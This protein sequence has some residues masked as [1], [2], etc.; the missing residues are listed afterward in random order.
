MKNKLERFMSS[1]CVK[2][3]IEP[4]RFLAFQITRLKIWAPWLTLL[5]F[6][7]SNPLNLLLMILKCFRKFSFVFLRSHKRSL[8]HFVLRPSDQRTV[9]QNWTACFWLIN[10]SYFYLKSCFKVKTLLNSLEKWW[11]KVTDANLF[12]TGCFFCNCSQVWL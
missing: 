3:F 12:K 1:C 6:L 11:W 8:D 7:F 2:I 10:G 4:K 5:K 9:R